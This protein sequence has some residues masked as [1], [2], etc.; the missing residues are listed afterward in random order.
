MTN[1]TMSVHEEQTQEFIAFLKELSI[2]DSVSID[3]IKS[4]LVELYVKEI[5]LEDIKPI[6]KELGVLNESL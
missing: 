3:T 6:H 4:I 5:E 1:Y 2:E